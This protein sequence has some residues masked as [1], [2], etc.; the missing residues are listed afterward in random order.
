[1]MIEIAKYTW[2]IV[3]VY[4]S[5]SLTSIV[6]NITEIQREEYDDRDS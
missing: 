1:M 6:I 4:I 2:Y 5:L 3:Y